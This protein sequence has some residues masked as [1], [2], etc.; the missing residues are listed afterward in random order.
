VLAAD[1]P[2]VSAVMKLPPHN[3][4]LQRTRALIAMRSS[5]AHRTP[6]NGHPLRTAVRPVHEVIGEKESPGTGELTERPVRLQAA[7]ATDRDREAAF[8]AVGGQAPPLPRTRVGFH[9]TAIT[10]Q[11][12]SIWK[13]S[14]EDRRHWVPPSPIRRDPTK[15]A[16]DRR[17][18]R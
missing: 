6:L 15:V 7:I 2:P 5:A 13:R 16:L 8:R 11:S 3:M 17:S 12:R 10:R 4:A 18:A 14:L 9:V 1:A